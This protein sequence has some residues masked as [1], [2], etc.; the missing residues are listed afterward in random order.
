MAK[1]YLG[2]KIEIEEVS[3]KTKVIIEKPKEYQQIL[4]VGR[5]K[6]DWSLY[7]LAKTQEKRLFYKLLSELCQIIQ[8]PNE[9]LNGRPKAKIKDLIFCMGIKLYSNYSGRKAYS[10]FIHAKDSG[11]VTKAPGVNTLNDFMNCPETF[12]LLSK[13]ITITAIPLKELEDHFS[14]DSS[15][16]GSYQYERWHNAKWK[17]KRGFRNYLKGH[18]S[19]GTRT[20]V[21]ASCEITPG[22]FSD[23]KQAPSLI[24]QTAANFNMK[25]FSGDK[26]YNSK[27]I[28]Q[29]VDNLGAIPF[30][31]FK[32]NV[33][34]IPKNSPEIWTKMLKLFHENREEFMH[35]YHKRSNVET[36]FSMVKVR[37]G[38]HL[39][40]RNFTSQRNE[41]AMK[42]LC[43]N[44]C[45]LVQEIF[46]NNVK[47][48]FEKCSE[49][50]VDRKVEDDYPKTALRNY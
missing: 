49:E 29:I 11:F 6:Q 41:L 10:D 31:P 19:I 33:K 45:C 7:H 18:I 17:T 48:D 4:P 50:Y 32:S 37:L 40:G 20:N 22:N 39:K 21:I 42:F 1:M 5:A 26:A 46:E 47:I 13:L 35:K 12:D 3:E 14:I 25:E 23:I 8:E 44:I 30:I 38:E 28:L 16:F 2:E 24:K 43:H 15:G 34:K 27:R 36:V 9:K